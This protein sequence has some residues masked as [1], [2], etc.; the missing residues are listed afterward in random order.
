MTRLLVVGAVYAL[1]VAVFGAIAYGL[2]RAT[3]IRLADRS[4]GAR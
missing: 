3:A 1:P 2:V 4:G